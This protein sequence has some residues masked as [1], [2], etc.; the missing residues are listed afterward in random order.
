MSRVAGLQQLD[1]SSPENLKR[2]LARLVR[3]L[4]AELDA[5]VAARFF[6]WNEVTTLQRGAVQAKFGQL[7]RMDT[8]AGQ[9]APHVYLP[10]G[11]TTDIG[12]RVGIS[13]NAN[14]PTCIVV[15]HAVGA[16]TIRYGTN[17]ATLVASL[18]SIR[19]L[20][21]TGASWEVKY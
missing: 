2:D 4:D 14:S 11:Q 1:T 15:A 12:K 6:E 16:Q 18:L 9:P 10:K 5:I 3:A 8:K 13:N 17:V 19:S 21:W 7:V 20:M